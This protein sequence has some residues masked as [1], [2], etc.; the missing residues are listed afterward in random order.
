[1]KDEKKIEQLENKR[2]K[3]YDQISEINREIRDEQLK[4]YDFEGK[5]I[6]RKGYGYMFVT[7][8]KYV[9]RSHISGQEEMFFQGWYFSNFFGSY[10]DSNYANYDAL[11]EWYIP[12]N[13]FEDEVRRGDIKVVSRGEIEKNWNEMCDE[14]REEGMK[15]LSIQEKNYSKKEEE[16]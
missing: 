8:Q 11:H 9:K 6:Y 2:E 5:Y 1:M 13:L 3:L 7:W 10:T 16:N 15:F 14:I 4:D 12:F